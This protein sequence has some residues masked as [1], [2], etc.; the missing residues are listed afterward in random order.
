[1][2]ELET[3]A[4]EDLPFT[5]VVANNGAWGNIRHEQGKQFGKQT[6][7]TVLDQWS[8]EKIAEAFGGHA[9]RVDNTDDLGPAIR[10]AVDSR[11]PAVVNVITERGVVSPITEMVGDMMK[12][13]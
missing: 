7:A 10:R 2:A 4:R 3:A 13:L 8:Y 5:C 11:K 6:G 9:E 12:M 1:M